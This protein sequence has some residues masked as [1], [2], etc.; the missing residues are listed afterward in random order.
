MKSV[1][2]EP[3]RTY[4]KVAAQVESEVVNAHPEWMAVL[5]EIDAIWRTELFG[6][7]MVIPP[8]AISLCQQGF[9]FWLAA[10]RVALSGH[11]SAMYSV[12]RTSF[13]AI[14]YAHLIA[15][16]PTL[17]EVWLTRDRDAVSRKAF[18]SQFG[19]ASKTVADQFADDSHMHGLIKDLYEATI[20]FGAHPNPRAVI[21]HLSIEEGG[22]TDPYVVT[23]AALNGADSINTLRSIVA[24][25][26]QAFVSIALSANAFEKHPRLP[27]LQERLDSVVGRVNELTEPFLRSS[28]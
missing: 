15:K 24:L 12:L 3:L 27:A 23:F 17:A 26:E 20:D 2:S 9:F 16:D 28:N 4:L 25:A 5:D 19:Q 8:V 6:E 22:A 18:R 13:E 21:D 1:Q 14:L 7:G 11:S 10:V